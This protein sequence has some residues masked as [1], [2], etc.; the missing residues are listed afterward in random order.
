MLLIIL[1]IIIIVSGEINFISYDTPGLYTLTSKDYGYAN[2]IIVE[3]WGGGG[4]GDGCICVGGGGAGGGAYIKAIIE[5]KQRNFNLIVGKGGNGGSGSNNN[6]KDSTNG[7]FTSLNSE[8]LNLTVGGGFAPDINLKSYGG[9]GGIIL[10]K[11]GADILIAKNGYN[12]KSSYCGV[13]A[14]LCNPVGGD[15]GSAVMGGSGGNGSCGF[16]YYPFC[17]SPYMMG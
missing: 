15:G 1:L 2:K 16:V 13:G 8:Y 4:G 7:N 17:S 14:W 11:V 5:T 10:S 6:C 12:G 9:K 3:L